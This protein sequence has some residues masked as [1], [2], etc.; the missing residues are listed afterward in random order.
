MMRWNTAFTT[1]NVARRIL[2]GRSTAAVSHSMRS[3]R[4]VAGAIASSSRRWY[5]ELSYVKQGDPAQ[6]LEYRSRSGFIPEPPTTTSSSADMH[7]ILVEVMAAPCNPADLNVVEGKYP[8]PHH[9]LE[10]SLLPHQLP[11]A[12]S[13]LKPE[14]CRVGGAEALGRVLDI[15]RGSSSSSRNQGQPEAFAIGDAVVLAESGWGSWRS[16]VW[17]PSQSLLRVPKDIITKAE[18]A[19]DEGFNLAQ[20]ALISQVAGTAY[21]LIQDF[22]TI[23]PG[24]VVIQNA[25]TSAVS[26][27]VAE[28]LQCFHPDCHLVSFVRR[29][30][31]EEG[32]SELVDLLTRNQ[33][34]NH[35]VVSEGT[36]LA[37]ADDSKQAWKEWKAANIPRDR[38]VIL[39]LNSVHGPQTSRLFFSL[40]SDNAKLVTYGAMSKQALPVPAAPLIFR[41]VTVC[42][43]WHS[44]WMVANRTPQSPDGTCPRQSMMDVLCNAVLERGLLLPPVH[45]V[46]LSQTSSGVQNMFDQVPSKPLRS[47]LVWNIQ[48]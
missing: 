7:W 40:L 24:D 10:E 47:K 42:G 14:P 5:Q 13:Y 17:V 12:T 16:H 19:N 21:R 45:T 37:A 23:R 8:S 4:F 36:A 39:G 29:Q 34:T 28:L 18:N 44:R 35:T 2:S 3:S 46:N 31:E 32:W 27:C 41:N 30:D 11:Y 26:M 20:A 25:G 48:K 1:A 33:T 9:G 15:R 6:Q 22:A 38:R 43:Y